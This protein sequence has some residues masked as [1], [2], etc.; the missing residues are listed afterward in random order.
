M[1]QHCT[2]PVPLRHGCSGRGVNSQWCNALVLDSTTVGHNVCTVVS[3][4]HSSDYTSASVPKQVR[5][6]WRTEASAASPAVTHSS[7]VTTQIHRDRTAR[8]NEMKAVL[9]DSIVGCGGSSFTV[10]C[11]WTDDSTRAAGRKHSIYRTEQ[12]FQVFEDRVCVAKDPGWCT[13]LDQYR[14]CGRTMD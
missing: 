14:R 6:I 3:V 10:R 9:L 11:R 8:P 1:L 12:R 5:S 13:A 7:L 4:T 2:Q